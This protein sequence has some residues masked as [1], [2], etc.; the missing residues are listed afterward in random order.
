M[1]A[2]A[3]NW[4]QG[5]VH[6]RIE[7]N[8]CARVALTPAVHSLKDLPVEMFQG[9]VGAI[10]GR[11]DVRDALVAKNGWT[12]DTLPAAAVVGTSSLRRQAQL[13]RARPDLQVRSIR[14][15]VR[16]AFAK[17]CTRNMTRRFC[18]SR[19][20]APELSGH[21]TQW[22]PLAVMLPAPGQGRWRCGASCRRCGD[23]AFI[24]G[25]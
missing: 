18:S 10:I 2:A 3:A 19:C 22:L 7:V 9:T 15:N 21:V 14:G 20:D 12:L 11:A 23:A 17:R 6:G 16:R 25:G 1:I 13:L 5:V 8:H 24:G 4:R